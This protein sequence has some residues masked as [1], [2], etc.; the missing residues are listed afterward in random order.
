MPCLPVL[1]AISCS[2]QSAKPAMPGAV[3]DEH[4]LVAQRR[5]CRPSRRRA[6]A[7]GLASSSSASRSAT[8][9][10]SS[11]SRAM[12]APARPLGTRPKAVSAR[13]AAADVGV[14]VDDAVAGLARPASSSGEPGSVTITIRPAG[15]MPASRERLLVGAPL[16]VGLDG[17]AGL[18]GHHHDRALEPV[19]E[20]G[21]GPGRGRW[22]PARSARRRAVAQMT[23][24]ASDEP[25]M[26]QSTTWSTP[27]S[28]S[29]LAQRRD[30]ADQRP[31]RRGAGRPRR[32]ASP[33]PPRPRDPTAWRPARRAC[34]R[35][36]RRRAPA[37]ARAIASAA[38]P[39]ADDLEASRSLLRALQLALDRL[40]ELVPGRHELVDALAAR[41][42]SIT[43]S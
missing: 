15:S 23:S 35:S 18:A 2:A 8:A 33:P 25:P 9:S 14:G 7:P 5:R 28:A 27:A 32:A 37:R 43:S 34:R 4:E 19:G 40:D 1:S 3:V 42:S 41:G 29:S 31:R 12:S 36:R 26:P 17:G 22:S 38:A 24:G 20:R 11:S 21:R 10:A 16:A 13:V 39:V 6:A 30:L